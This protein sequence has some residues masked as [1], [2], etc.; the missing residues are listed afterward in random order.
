MNRRMPALSETRWSSTPPQLLPSKM[1]SI[2]LIMLEHQGAD[3]EVKLLG[4]L[5]EEDQHSLR[6]AKGQDGVIGMYLIRPLR[7]H[8][9][10]VRR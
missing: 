10:L 7:T 5:Q 6:V 4:S 2:C 8:R 3:L 1:L 9:M